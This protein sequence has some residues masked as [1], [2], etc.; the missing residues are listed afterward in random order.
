MEYKV[1]LV[2]KQKGK[3]VTDSAI[4]EAISREE[5]EIEAITIFTNDG[6]KLDVGQF[7]VSAELN[8]SAYNRQL[9]QLTN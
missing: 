3:T 8:Q 4:V 7:K 2:S 5:A 1:I 9:D 6:H